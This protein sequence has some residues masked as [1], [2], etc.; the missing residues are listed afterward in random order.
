MLGAFLHSRSGRTGGRH[1]RKDRT[2]G[3]SHV[4]NRFAGFFIL[5]WTTAVALVIQLLYNSRS[6]SRQKGSFMKTISKFAISLCL[7]APFGGAAS[8]NAKLLDA[9]CPEAT[10]PAQQKVSEKIA[11]TCAP[12]AATTSFAIFADGKVYKLD[13]AGNE[14]V[15]SGMKNGGF[16][17][18]HDGDVHASVTGNLNGDIV[19]VDSISGKSETK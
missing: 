17:P 3:V 5:L 6:I 13:G 16:K 10:T 9:N 15:L 8:W 12:S 11:K 18:D 7:V 1:D 19:K 14:K 4:F 2:A